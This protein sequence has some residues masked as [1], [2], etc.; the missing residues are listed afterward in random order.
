MDFHPSSSVK[1]YIMDAVHCESPSLPSGNYHRDLIYCQ[2]DELMYFSTFVYIVSSGHRVGC[3]E[4]KVRIDI[5]LFKVVQCQ[6]SRF[7]FFKL[8]NAALHHPLLWLVV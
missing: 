4:V 1:T 3:G 7:N 5:D 8:S 6:L 2:L